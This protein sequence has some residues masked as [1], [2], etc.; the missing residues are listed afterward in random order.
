MVS[1]KSFRKVL[2]L[3]CRL[4]HSISL[5]E[6]H[7]LYFQFSDGS[8]SSTSSASNDMV[9]RS[10]TANA[11]FLNCRGSSRCVLLHFQRHATSN[12]WIGRLLFF[13]WCAGRRFAHIRGYL[14]SLSKIAEASTLGKLKF[15]ALQYM[16]RHGIEIHSSPVLV[17]VFVRAFCNESTH[18]V[19]SI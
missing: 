11:G 9:F 7:N 4:V 15:N 5:H 19:P 2:C 18:F 6:L 17:C 1:V 13:L 16:C 12:P 14:H 10:A 3:F 8:S